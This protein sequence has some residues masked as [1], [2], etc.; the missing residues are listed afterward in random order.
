MEEILTRI[1]QAEADIAYALGIFYSY[2]LWNHKRN[3][4]GRDAI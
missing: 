1:L 2:L 4:K 3:G